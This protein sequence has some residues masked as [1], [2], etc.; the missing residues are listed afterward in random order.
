MLR[1]VVP[2]HPV[3]PADH[4]VF[5]DTTSFGAVDVL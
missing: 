2:H 3:L 4:V 5:V 1:T